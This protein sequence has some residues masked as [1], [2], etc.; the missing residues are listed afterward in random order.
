MTDH[1][2]PERFAN[3]RRVF[4]RHGGKKAAEIVDEGC[5]VVREIRLVRGT[6]ANQIG[7]DYPEVPGQRHEH[8]AYLERRKVVPVAVAS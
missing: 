6:E 3:E 8:T 4:G 5:R 2:A 7:R 1:P